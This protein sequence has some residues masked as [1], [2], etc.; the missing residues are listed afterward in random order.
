MTA[1]DADPGGK[2]RPVGV[3]EIWSD[4]SGRVNASPEC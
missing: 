4:R 1:I 3:E 2:S